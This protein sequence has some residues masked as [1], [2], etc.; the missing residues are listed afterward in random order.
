MTLRNTLAIVVLLGAVVLLAACTTTP[1]YPAPS[2]T[3]A[4]SFPAISVLDM[5]Q[6]AWEKQRAQNEQVRIAQEMLARL[7]SPPVQASDA[8]AQQQELAAIAEAAV[9]GR[10]KIHA[11]AWCTPPHTVAVRRSR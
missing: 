6:R 4:A 3:L 5:E 10:Q 7:A 9:P 8:A 11:T 1:S 2:P